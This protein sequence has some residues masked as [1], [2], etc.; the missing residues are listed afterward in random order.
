MA[1]P[2]F[3]VGY[4]Y[5]VHR[6]TSGRPLILGGV[7]IPFDRGPSGHSDADVLLHA[8]IDAVLGA[9]ALG[10]IGTHFPDTDPEYRDVDSMLLLSETQRKVA[11]AGYAVVNV[12]ATVVLER[13]RL[14]PFIEQMQT[15]VQ[16]GLGVSKGLV[17]IKATTSESLGFVGEGRGV[18]A[19]AVCLLRAQ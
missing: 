8:I 10:D 13:P 3:R 9:A 15:N 12:D 16:D 5:D 6:M 17:S 7:H 18:V 4:G 1:D 2:L 11:A 19:H 14:A